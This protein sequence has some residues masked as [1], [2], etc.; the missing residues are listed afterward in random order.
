MRSSYNLFKSRLS[1]RI[2]LWVFA[3]IVVSEAIILIP[4]VYRR[5]QELL[6]HLKEISAAKASGVVGEGNLDVSEKELLRQIKA[7]QPNPVVKGGALYQVDGELVG[8][9]G[10][11]PEL[12]FDEIARDSDADF[13]NRERKRY[14][15]VWSM[16]PLVGRYILIIRH[17]TER[18][19]QELSA[20]VGRIAGLVLIISVFVTVTT[21]I[22]LERILIN[23]IL[24]LRRDLL[25]AGEAVIQER[26]GKQALEFDS[27]RIERRDEL[28]EV[29]AAFDQMFRQISEVIA[30]RKEASEALQESEERFRALVEQAV[31]AF[32]VVDSCGQFIDVNQRAC[33][34]LG[35]TREELLTLS[36]LN[37]QQKLTTEGFAELWKQ[38]APGVP[39]T[40]D[41]SHRRKDGTTFP[42]EVRIGLFEFAGRQLV[43]ALVRDVTERKQAEKAL[44]RLAEI[45]ELAAMIVHEVRNPL[46]TVLMG[47]NSFKRLDLPE[48]AQVRLELA[49]E[50][51]ERLQRL[52]NEILLYAKPQ[53]LQSTELELNEFI[54]ALLASMGSMPVVADR[55]V[56]FVPSPTPARVLADRDKLKQVFINLVSNACEAV[57]PGEVIT[58]QVEQ[59]INDR[60]VNIRIHNEGEPIPAD[61]IPKLTK[62]FY[63]TKASGNGLGLAITKRIVEVHRGELIIES[64][65]VAGTT[66]TVSLPL[67]A[68]LT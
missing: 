24:M 66:V 10:E 55:R 40:I 26:E 68:S 3:S 6:L 19:K 33:D 54:T 41:G 46:T 37:I 4:S 45:G 56:Q 8:V 23:P 34:T 17:D 32:F 57:S 65:A 59:K 1:Q 18:V 61:V 7:I 16:S 53:T 64:E 47:L 11:P 35:Y 25:R 30:K 5:E 36:V 2:V 39:V 15:A 67:V 51:S 43:L 44:E 22:V 29:I 63:T 14:D 49:L 38:L 31:D 62:P 13:L 50:E 48:R 60:R 20:F 27:V 58:C 52:L 42:V 28:G 21:M 9:F 12:S